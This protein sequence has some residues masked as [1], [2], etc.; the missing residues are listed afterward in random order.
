MKSCVRMSV[1]PVQGFKQIFRFNTERLLILVTALP[2][3]TTF[4]FLFQFKSK[5]VL[6]GEHNSGERTHLTASIR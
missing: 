6:L 3:G 4:R 1:S 5:H 2:G